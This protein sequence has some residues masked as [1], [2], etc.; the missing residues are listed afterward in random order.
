MGY[1][2]L[3]HGAAV[4]SSKAAV[5]QNRP[6]MLVFISIEQSAFKPVVLTLPFDGYKCRKG[7]FF[8]IFSSENV[9]IVADTVPQDWSDSGE[10]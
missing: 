2:L 5:F 10:Q 4:G 1:Q 7:Y 6:R 3:S 9:I 8:L